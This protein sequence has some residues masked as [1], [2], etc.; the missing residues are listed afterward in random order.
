[1]AVAQGLDVGAQDAAGG[2]GVQVDLGADPRSD[3]RDLGQRDAVLVV[4]LAGQG[5]Q[6]VLG[7][8]SSPCLLL[9][10]P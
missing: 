5:D 7:G 9:H 4:A 1:V 6:Q 8:V 10:H 3:R 2:A